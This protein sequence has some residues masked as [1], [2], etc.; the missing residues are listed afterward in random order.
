MIRRSFFGTSL[1]SNLNNSPSSPFPTKE[2]TNSSISTTNPITVIFGTPKTTS[3]NVS[4]RSTSR[5]QS[6]LSLYE[7]TIEEIVSAPTPS[8]KFDAKILSTSSQP[9]LQQF[10]IRGRLRSEISSKKINF[11]EGLIPITNMFDFLLIVSIILILFL[12]NVFRSHSTP[13]V[14]N[15]NVNV[16][17][18]SRSSSLSQNNNVPL[19]TGGVPA[20]EA[21]Q[22]IA[23][24]SKEPKRLGNVVSNSKLVNN[25]SVTVVPSAALPP[26]PP[27]KSTSFTNTSR[28]RSRTPVE[29][30][31]KI[32]QSP[33]SKYY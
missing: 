22:R 30:K 32:S 3:G 8:P 15:Y 31:T 11:R 23:I 17:S 26:Q 6:Y 13:Y 1:A 2:L 24:Y 28:Q 10:T 21:P 7:N 16:D 5:R 33:I 29:N 12:F 25:A 20:T 19:S 27:S 4:V 14:A 18:R 9:I